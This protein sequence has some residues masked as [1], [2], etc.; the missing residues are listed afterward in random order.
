MS[1]WKKPVSVRAATFALAIAVVLQSMWLTAALAAKSPGPVELNLPNGLKVLI[2]EE[3]SF[4]VV[5]CFMWYRVGARNEIPGTTGLSHLVEHLLFGNVGIFKKGEIGSAI[6]RNGGHFNGY[7][8][9]DFTTFFETLPPSKLDLAL[10][11]ES[12]RMRKAK[13]TQADVDSELSNISAEF[14]RKNKDP[15][16]VLS[17]E[18][19]SQAYQEH[20]YHHPTMGW[21]NDVKNLSVNDASAFYNR[22]FWPNNATLV[23]VG[24]VKASNAVNEV[25][26][27][28]GNIAKSPDMPA[29]VVPQEPEPKGE[30]RVTIKFAAK[31]EILQVAYHVPAI[32]DADARRWRYWKSYSMLHI[33]GD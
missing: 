28:F 22:Y 1:N 13:F 12:E 20:P 11:I 29:T 19:R 10:K 17:Q 32:T 14:E 18:V 23:I 15:L 7:T 25:K 3:Y 24:D 31:Q 21:L 16:E 27:Y 5:S 26:K 30:R 33:T 8:A 6:I 2:L 4:P 9:D